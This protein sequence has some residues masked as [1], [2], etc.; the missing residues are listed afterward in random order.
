MC[1]TSLCSDCHQKNDATQKTDG[2]EMVSVAT[3]TKTGDWIK[4]KISF[5]NSAP[6]FRSQA[7]KLLLVLLLFSS[8]MGVYGSPVK[9]IDIY[10]YDEIWHAYS[11]VL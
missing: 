5:F 11:D 6:F 9:P 10:E 1:L 4:L 2:A 8:Q 7:P 3:Q